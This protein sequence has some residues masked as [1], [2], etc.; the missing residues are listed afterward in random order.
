MDQVAL[1]VVEFF[2][3]QISLEPPV[4]SISDFLAEFLFSLDNFS[5]LLGVA[6]FD[7]SDSFVLQV[8]CHLVFYYRVPDTRCHMDLEHEVFREQA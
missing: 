3:P 5:V 6:T 8:S 7:T 1:L 4:S 2:N